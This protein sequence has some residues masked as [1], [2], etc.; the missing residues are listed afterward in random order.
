M[1]LKIPTDGWYMVWYM[2]NIA[3]QTQWVV[4]A[5][6]TVLATFTGNGTPS[7]YPLVLEMGR[8]NHWINACNPS[9]ANYVRYYMSGAYD[10]P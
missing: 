10:L 9:S 3:S 2:V 6:N 8:G 7:F 4:K 1:L 5:G